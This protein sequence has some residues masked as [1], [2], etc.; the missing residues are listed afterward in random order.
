MGPVNL[1]ADTEAAE[2][3]TRIG[4]MQADRED[5]LGAIA[6][7]RQGIAGL[8]REAASA[9]WPPLRPST[10]ISARSSPGCSAAAT[11]GWR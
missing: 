2:L 6:K 4:S 8:N 3:D 5:L 1:R 10:A 11:R 9:C 7:L